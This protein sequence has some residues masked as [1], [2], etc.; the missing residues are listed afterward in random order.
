MMSTIR[1]GSTTFGSV[2]FGTSGSA[3]RGAL[4]T[5]NKQ[6]TRQELLRVIKLLS[7]LESAFLCNKQ[8]FLPDYL[9]AEIAEIVDI[10]EDNIL[11]K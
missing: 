2:N 8:S 10:L 4:E 5:K 3:T 11:N 7:A 1:S 9:H 6:M